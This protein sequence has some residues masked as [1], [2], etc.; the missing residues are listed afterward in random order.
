MIPAQV[1]L[2]VHR[3]FKQVNVRV[4]HRYATAGNIRYVRKH[5]R[6][7]ID[8]FTCFPSDRARI[9]RLVMSLKSSTTFSKPWVNLLSKAPSWT[10]MST[11]F[12][13]TSCTHSAENH[14][15][16]RCSCPN[17]RQEGHPMRSMD[18][19]FHDYWCLICLRF[20]IRCPRSSSSR[21]LSK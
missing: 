1:H 13:C 14:V 20:C 10:K 17:D 3:G 12:A 16:S 9:K 6:M 19:A 18:N 2:S 11:P 8:I 7:N 21:N 15:L 5:V 4:C